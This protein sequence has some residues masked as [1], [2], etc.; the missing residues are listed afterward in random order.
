MQKTYKEKKRAFD[1]KCEKVMLELN[2]AQNERQ[3]TENK[4]F[5]DYMDKCN[6]ILEKYGIFP[7]DHPPSDKQIRGVDAMFDL[8]KLK[9]KM[10]ELPIIE[11]YERKYEKEMLIED[12]KESKSSVDEFLETFKFQSKKKKRRRRNR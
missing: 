6:D 2:D 3:K 8:I 7:K 11:N 4:A 5:T 1:E 10:C 12:I 9:R